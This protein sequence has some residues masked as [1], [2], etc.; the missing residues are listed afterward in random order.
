MGLVIVKVV[1]QFSGRYDKR[2]IV[3]LHEWNGTNFWVR[4]HINGK[5][6][7]VARRDLAEC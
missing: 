6:Y 3:R 1:N 2:G 5:D 4:L 7:L